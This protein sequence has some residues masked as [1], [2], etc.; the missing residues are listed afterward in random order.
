[1]KT[2]KLYDIDSYCDKFEA[3]VLKCDSADK[4]Y[5]IV[6]DQTAFFPEGGGQY[7]DTGTVGD[8]KVF[9]VQIENGII[10]HYCDKPLLVNEKYGAQINFAERFDKM[11]QH[12][13]EH[14][15]SGIVHKLYGYNNTGFH[16][17][18][19]IVT[20]DFDGT[21]SR[22]D[23][24]KIE[25]L[26]N[27][28]VHKNKKITAEYPNAQ[29]LKNNAYRSKLELTENV[30]LVTIDGY[31]ICACCAPHV[32][33][34][35]E[36]GIIK[37][38][39]SE[40]H[41]GGVRITIKC[42][43]RAV[44]D[45]QNKHLNVSEISALLKVPQSDTAS[46]VNTLLTDIDR[47]KYEMTGI[48]RELAEMKLAQLP[49]TDGNL[50]IIEENADIPSLRYIADKGADKCNIFVALGTTDSGYSFVVCSKKSDLKALLPEIKAKLGLI[51]GGSS[52]M[53]QGK[54][55][56]DKDTVQNFFEI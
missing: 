50:V 56:A 6:L 32:K 26:A 55:T 12:S 41:K 47:L 44:K 43:M 33:S 10:Y 19:N 2:I 21:F 9:D 3:T 28:A 52:T 30:R 16:L 18:D 7:S 48:K 29:T 23:L 38:L 4:G 53:L 27:E 13:G 36:I 5:K 15:I 24:D 42:G 49:Q 20:L 8:A 51:G 54:I 25:I 34:T 22:T 1:M 35:G 31:D 39:E 14:I 45:Y 40:K 46:A 17:S 37:L 11:Q